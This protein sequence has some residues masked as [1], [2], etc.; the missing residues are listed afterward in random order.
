MFDNPM[1]W[2]RV[3]SVVGATNQRMTIFDV[4]V[5]I[6]TDKSLKQI[7]KDSV[8]ESAQLLFDPETYKSMQD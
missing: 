8:R 1:Y 2:T 7:R 6:I 4:E 5:D 3:K